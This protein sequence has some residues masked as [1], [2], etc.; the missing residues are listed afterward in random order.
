[1]LA[2]V[3]NEDGISKLHM[4]G[5]LNGLELRVPELPN[6]VIGNIRWHR[7]GAFLGIT[8]QTAQAQDDCYSIEVSNGKVERWTTSESEVR[9]DAFPQAELV[10]WKSFDGK[11]ISGFLYNPPAKCTG[12]RT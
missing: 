12:K 6:G 7:N 2:Y 1:M 10:R 3:T 9:T 4:R 5:A 8:M 11:M